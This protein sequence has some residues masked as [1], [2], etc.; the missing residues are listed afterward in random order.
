[1]ILFLMLGISAIFAAIASC[2]LLNRYT[3]IVCSMCSI[4]SLSILNGIRDL[5]VGTDLN[6]Y[7]NSI[8]MQARANRFSL[9]DFLH[10]CASMGMDER[11]Y[12]ALN[13]IIAQ[14]TDNI[15]IFYFILGLLVNGIFYIAFFEM[16]SK[17]PFLLVWVTYLMIIYPSTL[18]LLRQ[19]IALSFVALMGCCVL[20]ERNVLSLFCVFM[21]IMFHNSAIFAI[22]IYA[23][24]YSESRADDV[25]VQNVTVVLFLMFSTFIPSLVSVMNSK[26]LL[27]D[28]YSQY[29]MDDSS[30]ISLLNSIIVRILFVIVSIYFLL[31]ER[32]ELNSYD[33][34]LFSIIVADFLLIPLQSI[35][36]SAFRIALYYSIF[37]IPGYPLLCCKFR[38]MKNITYS[39]YIIFTIMYFYTQ[40]IKNGSGQIF[41]FIVSPDVIF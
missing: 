31:K 30:G 11:G 19:S 16:R 17:I 9:Q 13:F 32:N 20:K 15:H 10:E 34:C 5:S 41:P 28:K 33:K 8:F 26:G 6:V 21:A 38:G 39:F 40:T 25:R 1:M 24:M 7:G 29:V 2:N 4:V 18:N 12:A 35:S 36:P 3:V 37:K 27:S 14:F 23:F 22:V